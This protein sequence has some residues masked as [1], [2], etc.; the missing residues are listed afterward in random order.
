MV[1]ENRSEMFVISVIACYLFN[2][3]I[4]CLFI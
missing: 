2:K 1:I 3:S 4:A